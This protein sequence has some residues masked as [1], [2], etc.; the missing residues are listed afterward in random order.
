LRVRRLLLLLAA[1]VLSSASTVA[2]NTAATVPTPSLTWDTESAGVDRFVAVHGRRAL[3]SGYPR[4]GLEVWA[5]PLEIVASYRPSFRIEGMTTEINGQTILRR[6]TYSPDS[7]SRT[8]IGPD[9]EIREKLFVPLGEPGAI[10]TYEIKNSRRVDIII[11]FSPVLDLMW[12]ASIGGQD[13]AWNSESSGFIL[14]EPTGKF[15]AII[16]SADAIAHDDTD[17]VARRGAYQQSLG[18]TIRAADSQHGKV[19]TVVIAGGALRAGSLPELARRLVRSKADLE[20]EAAAHY[21]ELEQHALRIETPDAEVNR[22]LAWSQIALDQSWVCNPE[23][24]CG[25]VAGYGPSR[26][27]RRPQ[28]A[29]FFAGD[30]L[31]AIQALLAEGEFSRA[32]AELEFIVKYQ[33]QKSGMIWHEIS[34][35]AGS[36]DWAGKYPYMYAHVDTTFQ[37]LA[38][39]NSYFS[40]TDDIEFLK[41]H[42]DSIIAAQKF[43]RSLLDPSD[44]LPRIPPS[45]EGQS[46]QLAMT[47]ELRLSASWVTAAEAYASM[48]ASL[49][50]A[51][52][53]KEARRQTEKATGAIA[54]RY[55]SKD[56]GSWITGYSRNG[57]PIVD[58]D[59]GGSRVLS[60][61]VFALAQVDQI[62]DRI[63]TSDYQ[64]DWG[65]RS[66]AQSA[67][68]YDPNSYSQGSVW[69]TSTAETALAFWVE[70]R[71]ATA[72]PMWRA[73]LPWSSLDSLGH[74]HEALAGD[75]YHEELESVSEQTWSS[76]TFLTSAVRGMLG[77]TIDAEAKQISF[78][79][80]IPADWPKISVKNIRVR[81]SE[82]GLI[83]TQSETTTELQVSNNG[84][85]VKML[86]SPQ[87]PFGATLDAADANGKPIDATLEA[88]SQDTHATLKVGLPAGETRLRIKY[89]GGVSLMIPPQ[90]PIVGD[91]SRGIKITGLHWNEKNLVLQ[92]DVLGDQ[93]STFT[94]RTPWQVVG[95][96]GASFEAIGQ[97]LYR[98]SIGAAGES[99]AAGS[100]QH[101]T[102]VLAF[103]GNR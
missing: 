96:Q 17:N 20:K 58:S 87:I 75:F 95:V 74:M 3:I 48:A 76:A 94:L 66:M 13:I 40:A 44:G 84:G 85:P 30:A 12:P 37:Y 54:Q 90:K 47:D 93:I 63:A 45:K 29:W 8:Y 22:T 56:R 36:L 64:T 7:V 4:E 15:A 23:L 59:I 9:F 14:S 79:P 57:E 39:V 68:T 21:V 31:V 26:K 24:G 49:G 16:S 27:A 38:T 78:I 42:W 55:W 52:E 5:Y 103:A 32:R 89:S 80:H 91:A 19:A 6:V 102:V 82:L 99:A 2:Q 98:L 34:Q 83:L 60:E 53:A 67:A 97:N 28:Y 77:L 61:H 69:G 43:C 86:F 50:H 25:I 62:L 100:Y 1:L 88:N 51:A 18:F 70:H 92:A 71:P 73:L 11:R 46:E 81:E 41:S 101:S 72:M 33:D 65:S 35:S 10:I